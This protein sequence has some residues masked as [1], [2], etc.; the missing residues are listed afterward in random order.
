MKAIEKYFFC[1]AVHYAVQTVE[2]MG[3]THSNESY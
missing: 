3:E 1:G 2:S